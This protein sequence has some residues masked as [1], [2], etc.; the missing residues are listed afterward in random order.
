MFNGCGLGGC[1]PGGPGGVTVP[2]PRVVGKVR[3]IAPAPQLR[4]LRADEMGRAPLVSVAG[5]ESE[6]K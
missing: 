5:G 2:G 3:V 4:S 6:N 1:G